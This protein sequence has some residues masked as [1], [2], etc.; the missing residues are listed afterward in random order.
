MPW[1]YRV[2]ISASKTDPSS[3]PKVSTGPLGLTKP[4]ART[5]KAAICSRV[6]SSDGQYECAVQP[7]V[8]P[9]SLSPRTSPLK[10]WSGATSSNRGAI[11]TSKN[12]ERRPRA[13]RTAAPLAATVAGL[14]VMI[15]DITTDLALP[16]SFLE[17]TWML[18][19]HR[20]PNKDPREPSLNQEVQVANGLSA[21]PVSEAESSTETR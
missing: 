8:M 18:F 6:T 9:R 16:D 11:D 2:S 20:K 14:S 17:T 1:W 21:G 5:R 4:R 3:S 19:N 7:E 12:D 10:G 15:P 13:S